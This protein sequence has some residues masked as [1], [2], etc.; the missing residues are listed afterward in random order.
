VG[1]ISTST[2]PKISLQRPLTK[3]QAVQ[4]AVEHSERFVE[5]GAGAGTAGELISAGPLSLSV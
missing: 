1:I 2:I 5:Q 4:M 3:D